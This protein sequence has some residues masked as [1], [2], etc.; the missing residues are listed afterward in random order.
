M[1]D[2]ERGRTLVDCITTK[3]LIILNDPPYKPTFS[4]IK[5][6]LDTLA[7]HLIGI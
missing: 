4:L 3:Q 2:N 7:D 5:K 6:P 1:Y